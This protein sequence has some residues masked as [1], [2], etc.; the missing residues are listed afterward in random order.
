MKSSL[1]LSNFF[2]NLSIINV[3]ESKVI[4]YYLLE[5]FWNIGGL[6][7]KKF[8]T[9]VFSIPLSAVTTDSNVKNEELRPRSTNVD[10]GSSIVSRTVCHLL[11]E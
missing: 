3:H 6:M 7:S 1:F 5:Y 8:L 9:Q 10:K 11:V 2:N 4:W